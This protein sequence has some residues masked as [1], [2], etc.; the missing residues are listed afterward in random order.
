MGTFFIK[1][2]GIGF[3]LIHKPFLGVLF[4]YSYYSRFYKK[5]GRFPSDNS[6]LP[7]LV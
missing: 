5:S 1:A 2:F 6:P 7:P 4:L 3:L